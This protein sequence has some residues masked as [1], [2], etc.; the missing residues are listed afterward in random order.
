MSIVQCICCCA[1][2][3]APLIFEALIR[4]AIPVQHHL[5]GFM[6]ITVYHGA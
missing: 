1:V 2:P 6:Y 3:A 5:A 4:E